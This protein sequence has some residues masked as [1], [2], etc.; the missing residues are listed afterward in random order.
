M[1]GHTRVIGGCR[2]GQEQTCP[3]PPPELADLQ[4]VDTT[5]PR[6]VNLP[7]PRVAEAFGVSQS[8]GGTKIWN[9]ARPSAVSVTPHMVGRSAFDD[10]YRV[11]VDAVSGA[12]TTVRLRV[13][14]VRSPG[15]YAHC[16]S[17]RPS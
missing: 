9:T 11:V 13:P 17:A 5:D 14:K 3:A 7:A 2:G 12:G 1:R 6:R 10:D 15:N 4:S 8:T 16:R